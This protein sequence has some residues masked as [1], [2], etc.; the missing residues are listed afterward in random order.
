MNKKLVCVCSAVFALILVS[1]G[2]SGTSSADGDLSSSSGEVLSSSS[3]VSS[4]SLNPSSSSAVSSSSSTP[5]SSS[6]VISYG[7]LTDMRDNQ[8]YK[9]VVIGTQ[10][11]MAENLNF[12]T[13]NGTGSWCYNDSASY[14]A[15]YGRLYDWTTVMAGSASSD[16]TPSGVQGICPSGWHVPSDAEWT[17]LT[18]FVGGERTAGTQL[19]ANSSLWSTNT[20]TDD[21]GFSALPSGDYIRSD[22]DNLGYSGRWWSATVYLSLN[23]YTRHMDFYNA[24][25]DSDYNGKTNGFSLRCVKN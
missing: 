6:V 21:Y 22:F 1:C 10:T 5:S 14:C 18:N 4:S 11:W 9:T 3:A 19:K 25:V 7:S 23:A 12:D 8:I 20:G 13:L 24:D 16:A 15:T 17:V 2:D